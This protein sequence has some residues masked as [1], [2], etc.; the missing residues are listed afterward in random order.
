MAGLVDLKQ[1]AVDSPGALIVTTGQGNEITFALQN[2]A[3]QLGRWRLVHDHAQ[4]FGKLRGFPR[5]GGGQSFPID[6]DRRGRHDA[7]AAPQTLE[8]FTL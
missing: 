5:F 2:F 7:A 4:R 1:V 8:S 3:A 6:L